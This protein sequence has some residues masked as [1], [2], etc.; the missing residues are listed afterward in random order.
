MSS[1]FLVVAG[2]WVVDSATGRPELVSDGAKLV[3]DIQENLTIFVQPNG[4]GAGLDGLLGQPTDNFTF[5]LQVSQAVTAAITAQQNLQ[6]QFLA[7][8][9]PD[10]ELI[11][12]IT[13]LNVM[14][15]DLGGGVANTGY[16]LTVTV[17]S[18]AGATVST[19]AA[20]TT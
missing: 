19:T 6:E 3:Q 18:A 2:D 16:L 15:T 11:N 7:S 5:Q 10:T 8:Q 9:R 17:A 12:G 1:T 4:F 14:P 13:Y 20:L